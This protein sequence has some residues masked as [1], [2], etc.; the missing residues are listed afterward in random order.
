MAN[1]TFQQPKDGT[2]M[3]NNY[4][5]YELC[6]LALRG[7]RSDAE[8][9]CRILFE[10]N[11]PVNER[12]NQG[13]TLPEQKSTPLDAVQFRALKFYVPNRIMEE[14][15]E[16]EEP[17]EDNA[18]G[19]SDNDEDNKEK[20]YSNGYMYDS[21]G[22]RKKVSIPDKEDDREAEGEETKSKPKIIQD[23]DSFKVL[24]ADGTKGKEFSTRKEAEDYAESITETKEFTT[25]D[26][27]HHG[28]D[29]REKMGYPKRSYPSDEVKG[30]YTK[31]SSSPKKIDVF[32][33]DTDE[34]IDEVE[35]GFDI[36]TYQ[37]P[38]KKSKGPLDRINMRGLGTNF[39]EGEEDVDTNKQANESKASLLFTDNQT[40]RDAKEILKEKGVDSI[41]SGST[42]IISDKLE[43]IEILEAEG[44]NGLRGQKSVASDNEEDIQAG[45]KPRHPPMEN[46]DELYNAQKDKNLK[47]EDDWQE[48]W[49]KKPA[50]WDTW[51]RAEKEEYIKK[52]L[53]GEA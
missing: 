35:E 25:G 26:N 3:G 13:D 16:H 8:E 34:K 24:Y 15:D 50:Q 29:G 46:A 49:G 45:R 30:F 1:E 37:R 11:G 47:S 17:D 10:G 43:A 6:V 12:A 14:E 52:T 7:K 39:D 4:D 20:K 28:V 42:L 2:I 31:P 48:S 23:G 36:N 5:S 9:Y 32:D 53:R 18:G 33:T 40:A 44:M 41:V 19:L 22:R 51:S 38:K 21:E 27:V